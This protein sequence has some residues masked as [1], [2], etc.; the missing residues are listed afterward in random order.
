MSES[1]SLSKPE[2]DSSAL[3]REDVKNLFSG[4]PHFMLERGQHGRSFPQ[5]LFPN[6]NDLDVADL[7][8]RRF[9]RHESFALATLHAHVPIP[10]AHTYHLKK[11]SDALTTDYERWNRPPF[12]VGVF[13]VPNMLGCEGKELGTVGMR[14]FL[15]LAVS[16]ALT[17]APGKRH[18]SQSLKGKSEKAVARESFQHLSHGEGYALIGKYA[19][20]QDRRRVMQGG[21][22]AWKRAGIRDFNMKMIGDRLQEISRVHEELVSEGMK[23]SAFDKDPC[24]NLYRIIFTQFL[25]PPEKIHDQNPYS[26]KVQV[27]TLVKVLTTPGVWVDFSQVEWRL[28]LGQ[29]LF[30]SPEDPMGDRSRVEAD[31][32][33][34]WLH[35]QILL[36]VELLIRLDVALRIGMVDTMK[37][38]VV[39]PHEIHHFNHL[40]NSKVDWDLILARRFVDH[41]Q[42]R[43]AS[44]LSESVGVPQRPNSGLL[45]RIKNRLSIED[46]GPHSGALGCVF[47]PRRA[48]VQLEGLFR[49]ARA[50]D[51]PNIDGFE[52]LMK[53]KFVAPSNGISSAENFYSV[54]LQSPLTPPQ[55]VR[56][57]YFGSSQQHDNGDSRNGQSS[58]HLHGAAADQ[59]GGWLSRSWLTGLVLPGETITYLLMSTLLEN[60]RE[61][62]GKIGH[63]AV[64]RGGFV[65]DSRSFWSK[66]CIVGRVVGSFD[67]G[68]ECMGWVSSP[69]IAPVDGFDK[70][71]ANGWVRIEV[72]DA[73]IFRRRPRIHDGQK[74]AEESSFLG[75][76]ERKVIA[77]E[78][79]MPMDHALDDLPNAV[80]DFESVH[81][82][83]QSKQA[84][85]LNQ[86]ATKYTNVTVSFAITIPETKET[87]KVEIPLNYD[88]YFITAHPCRP[89][90]G[91]IASKLEP[92]RANH[93]P[94]NNH[95]RLPSHPLHSTYTYKLKSIADILANPTP[96]PPN[97]SAPLSEYGGPWILDARGSTAKDLLVRSWCAKVGRHALIARVGKTCFS[98]CVREARALEVAIIVRAGE[99]RK[100]EQG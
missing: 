62:L 58:L 85:A 81:L 13:E 73:P 83:S 34:N 72:Q 35:L 2:G 96:E 88:V 22:K 100:G 68:A 20:K 31:A 56:I 46:V 95:E 33:R 48:H 71:L 82:R 53:A 86:D 91:H 66:S 75:V 12:D 49:F 47:L 63:S 67:G 51:W 87:S 94:D 93:H 84:D 1:V 37:E 39:T 27:E 77:T 8:D 3:R 59:V 9:L 99:G 44:N 25:F 42:V 14:H 79:T 69:Q 21:P 24:H 41:V 74:M 4:A 50:I 17:T 32:E 7:K 60:D 90:H 61:V 15:E 5:A 16:D 57:S 92:A 40:R 52:T 43:A 64:L 26:L 76:G 30:R 89:P 65:L 70:P 10:D 97:P 28:R 78:F 11:G 29:I 54:P 98:C 6:D 45:S 19:P 55:D 23:A 80:V 18:G 38:K 36:S